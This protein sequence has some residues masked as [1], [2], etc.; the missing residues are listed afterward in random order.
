MWDGQRVGGM[1]GSLDDWREE[2]HWGSEGRV[3][4]G[5]R[6]EDTVWRSE[7]GGTCGVRRRYTS[8]GH[9]LTWTLPPRRTFGAAPG[10][11][12][13]WPLALGSGKMPG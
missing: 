3:M 12:F 8:A 13:G 11:L 7:G 6:K 4:T 5:S 1:C 10:A 9:S 2:A